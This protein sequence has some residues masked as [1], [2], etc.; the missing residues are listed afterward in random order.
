[1][2]DIN[3]IIK[4]KSLLLKL[5]ITIG[6]ALFFINYI[7]CN[8]RPR[9]SSFHSGWWSYADQ[10]R[11]YREV[12]AWAH[13]DLAPSQHWYL[14]MYTLIG[15]PF[16]FVHK[17]D[18]FIIPDLICFILSIVGVSRLSGKIL[19]D[20]PYAAQI[21]A[22]ACL[23][24]WVISP[25]GLLSWVIPWTTTLATPLLIWLFLFADRLLETMQPKWASRCGLLFGL[26]ALTRPTEAMWTALPVILYCL[27]GVFSSKQSTR[28]IIN[29][30]MV[31]IMTAMFIA[32]VGIFLHYIC[33]GSSLGRYLDDSRQ[34]GFELGSVLS[35]W[36]LHV[37]SPFPLHPDASLGMA[38]FF[39]WLLPGMVGIVLA[40]AGR[41][42][43]PI[44]YVVCAAIVIHWIVYL[45]Y[46]DLHPEGLWR[47]NNYHYFKWT[48][49]FFFI[50]FI[51]LIYVFIK[52]S[53]KTRVF[54]ALSSFMILLLL[55]MW[56]VDFVPL[57]AYEQT[58]YFRTAHEIDIPNGLTTY[59]QAIR[60]Q[61]KGSF[62]SIN[63][64]HSVFIQA[65]QIRSFN[66]N[67]KAWPINGGFLLESL[68]KLP[69]G[70]G[71]L[72]IGN[73]ITPIVGSVPQ[74]GYIVPHFG[75]P[76]LHRDVGPYTVL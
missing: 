7:R 35:Q 54:I 26:L 22:L 29:C 43:P 23:V 62:E 4:N 47:Y 16:W 38:F 30:V 52:S 5:L 56:R 66:H 44:S 18:P 6:S 69:S 55:T 21:G 68:R 2:N 40:V 25:A 45:S 17:V 42:L 1:M 14:P 64:N 75:L 51:N 12:I 3:K 53:K 74:L 48:Q 61:A 24:T 8:I 31:G 70:P 59:A 13:L 11:Y 76:C 34:T 49:P 32:A 63:D 36:V 33:Y 67:V 19:P 65:G 60:V 72:L 28:V 57:P 50:F 46:R 15:V 9:Y 73:D 41:R 58:A 71:R 27:Y 10:G 37:I 20:L 39:W